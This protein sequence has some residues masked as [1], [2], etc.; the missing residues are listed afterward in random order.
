M[1][2][3][4]EKK[5][6]E[7]LIIKPAKQAVKTILS[8][9]KEICKEN[10][11]SKPVNLIRRLNP[12]LRGWANYHRHVCSK[13]AFSRVD[14]NI[15][16]MILKWAK[17]R[18]PNKSHQYIQRK[19]FTCRGGDNWVF[20]DKDE[21]GREKAL[22]KIS[23]IPIQRHLK[24]QGNANPYDPAMELYFERRLTKKWET[25]W[26]GK[27]KVLRLWKQ[28]KGKCPYCAQAISMEAGPHIHHIIYRVRGGPDTLNNLLLL[29]P[30]CHRQLHANDNRDITGPLMGAFEMLE[31]QAGK[32]A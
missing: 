29:H 10:R 14:W 24:I 15:G 4:T 3:N 22:L 7:K 13:K 8:K 21:Q 30:E 11:S 2:A 16:A 20:S 9:A 25:G 19:Y 23:Q 5:G 1:F 32:L 26:Q 12:V 17:R 18:H 6:A 28:Q 31:P 27:R